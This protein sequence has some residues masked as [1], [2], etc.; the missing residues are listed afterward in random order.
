MMALGFSRRAP[1]SSSSH[2]VVKRASLAPRGEEAGD[3]IIINSSSNPF[4]ARC[5][6]RSNRRCRRPFSSLSESSRGEEGA[7]STRTINPAIGSGGSNNNSTDSDSSPTSSSSSTER[8]QRKRKL[9]HTR[10]PVLSYQDDYVIVSKP[11]GMSMHHNSNT[12][13]GRSKSPVL[14]NTIQ[15]QL[16]RKPYLVHRLDHR[17]SGAVVLGFDSRTAGELHGR[18]RMEDATKLYV[19]LVRGDL[20]ELFRTAATMATASKD[21][22]DSGGVDLSVDG[23]GS[24]VGSR[25]RAPDIHVPA[26]EGMVQGPDARPRGSEHDGRITVDLPLRIDGVPKEARTDFHF[27]ASMEEEDASSSDVDGPSEAVPYAT[28]SLTLLLCRPRTG[29]THQIRRHAQRALRAPVIGDSEHGDSRVNRHWRTSV[30]LDRLGL[31]CWFLGLPPAPASSSGVGDG[32][33][34]GDDDD[35]DDEDAGDVEGI[36]CMAPLT[37]DFAAALRHERLR[38]LWEEATSVEPRLLME[39]YDSRG[40]TFGR[41]FRKKGA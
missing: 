14:Q 21:G 29:R 7:A 41:N 26:G 22:I 2:A 35:D 37:P 17:T 20:R 18:L 19:A 32:D 16:S 39:P 34:D 1:S 30:G 33:K 24:V 31:H 40:G 13:W 6:R 25:G 15:K 3:G 4:F 12:R 23:D 5:Q 9:R 38:P 27:L 11:E 28:T 36:S 10:I 8:N